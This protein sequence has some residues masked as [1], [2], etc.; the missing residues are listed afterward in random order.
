MVTEESTASKSPAASPA[1]MPSQAV[2]LTTASKPAAL[3]TAWIMSMSKPTICLWAST[4][5]MGGKVQ[6]D[7][8]TSLGGAARRGRAA[9]AKVV[10]ARSAFWSRFIF[11][12][13]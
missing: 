12:P 7:P 8:N 1:K 2:F 10:A 9:M 3:A 4:I 5:S 6:S 11:S 13:S